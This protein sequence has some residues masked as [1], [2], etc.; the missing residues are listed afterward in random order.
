MPGVNFSL[1]CWTPVSS[2]YPD[3][4]R[5]PNIEQ[6]IIDCQNKGKKV[7]ISLGGATGYND[8][9]DD[10]AKVLA[11]NLWDLFLEGTGQQ[12]IRPFGRLEKDSVFMFQV[13][14]DAAWELEPRS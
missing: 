6:G 13:S 5:C 10:D 14:P 11:Q 7:L 3:L 4:Y 2:E 1:H 8:L 9:N 12:D